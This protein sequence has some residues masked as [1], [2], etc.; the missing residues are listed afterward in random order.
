[1]TH[2]T[3]QQTALDDFERQL[4]VTVSAF[5][6]DRNGSMQTLIRIE[7]SVA[8]SRRSALVLI[9][10]LSDSSQVT[11]KLVSRLP[12]LIAGWPREW[13]VWV[14]ALADRRPLQSVST[15]NVGHVQDGSL[16]LLEPFSNAAA[17]E[18]YRSRGS[19]LSPTLA[20]INDRITSEDIPEVQVV[21]IGDAQPD[22]LHA[23]ERAGI[24]ESAGDGRFCSGRRPLSAALAGGRR[25]CAA[26][27]I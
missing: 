1:M 25:R 21:L 8:Q 22:R 26:P 13:P 10:D 11:A 9:Y 27:R 2:S 6:A 20:A 14:Y 15:G 16:D 18:S 17:I 7:A 23:S 12:A 5:E 4:G 24:D 3:D 19:F